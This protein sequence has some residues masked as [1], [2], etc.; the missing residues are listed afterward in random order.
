MGARSFS[1]PPS[2]TPDLGGGN[3][4]LT[5]SHIPTRGRAWGGINGGDNG[6]GDG[7]G[8]GVALCA[9]A[10]THATPAH[11]WSVRSVCMRACTSA[12]SELP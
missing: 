2:V 12:G 7:G 3:C 8:S 6:G 11:D 10:V 4:T 5:A 1:T 9:A